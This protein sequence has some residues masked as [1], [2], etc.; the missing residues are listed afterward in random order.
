MTSQDYERHFDDFE[1]ANFFFINYQ[2]S[3]ITRV[4][5]PYPKYVKEEG[6]EGRTVWCVCLQNWLL[7]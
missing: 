6:C 7:H 1:A 3:P 2:A 5:A 4:S